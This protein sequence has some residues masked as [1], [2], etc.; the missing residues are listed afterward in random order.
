M[1]ADAARKERTQLFREFLR[2]PLMTRVF[3]GMA[4][5]R[6]LFVCIHNSARSQM[7]EAFLRHYGGERFE[8]HSAGL[9]AGRLNPIVL[10][11]MRAC[12]F[13]LS[14]AEAKPLARYLAAGTEFDYVVTVCDE[15]SAERCPVFP[16]R[17]RRLHW[18]FPDP[19]ALAG[20]PEERFRETEVIRDRI[21]ERV[22]QWLAS[23][24]MRPVV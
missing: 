5:I 18:S 20:T 15:A 22:Q 21:E 7:A 12:G 17:T 16:G 23:P 13:D 9:E 6:V 2:P 14:Q 24:E 1:S 11:A 4:P 3:P 8:A 10:E 19:S